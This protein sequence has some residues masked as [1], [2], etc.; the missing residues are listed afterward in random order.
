MRCERPAVHREDPDRD[1]RQR[2]GQAADD[3]GLRAVGVDDV[4]P[5]AAEQ[6]DELGEAGEV[7]KRIDGAPNVFEGDETSAVCHRGFLQRAGA[8]G[9][10]GDVEVTCERRKQRSDVRLSPAD[11]GERDQQQ[12][13]RPAPVGI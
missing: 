10:N 2:G 7:A 11:L 1:A 12:K 13:A 4:R 9:R 3:A 6:A 5:F 8:V